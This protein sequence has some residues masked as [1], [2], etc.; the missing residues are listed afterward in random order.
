M[1]TS[2]SF[3]VEPK[4]IRPKLSL[5]AKTGSF[6]FSCFPAWDNLDMSGLGALCE[7][8]SVAWAL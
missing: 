4:A 2:L 8:G 5:V 3:H 1:T 6:P 7:E